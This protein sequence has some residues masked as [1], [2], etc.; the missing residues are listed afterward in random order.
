M[1]CLHMVDAMLV[2]GSYDTTLKV[3]DLDMRTEVRT[4]RHHTAAVLCVHVVGDRVVSGTFRG[5][6][7]GTSAATHFL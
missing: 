2:S 1:R 7:V 4:L 3:W 5:S 6:R